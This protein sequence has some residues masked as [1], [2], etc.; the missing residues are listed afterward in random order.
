MG[1][2]AWSQSPRSSPKMSVE[3][4]EPQLRIAV[5]SAPRSGNTWLRNMLAASFSLREIAVHRPEHVDWSALP[6]RVVLQTHWDPVEP[7]LGL[8]HR[9]DFRVVTV[10]RHPLDL[11]L[12]LLNL[13]QY[14]E[15]APHWD[16]GKSGR[17]LV[18][19][20]PRSPDFLEFACG[21]MTASLLSPTLRWLRTPGTVSVRYEDLV[22][23]TTGTLTRVTQALSS[24]AR[25]PADEVA[26][27]Y[28]IERLRSGYGV[29]HYHYWQGRPGHWKTLLTARE[30]HQIASAHAAAFAELGYDC[31]PDTDLDETQA[32]L[33]WYRLQCNSICKHL[34]DERTKHRL[35][36]GALESKEEQLA[37]AQSALADAEAQAAA[38]LHS[39]A[40]LRQECKARGRALA[41]AH[42]ELD[43]IRQ[44]SGEFETLGPYSLKV[45][46][47]V[48]NFSR[49]HPLLASAVKQLVRGRRKTA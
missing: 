25:Q 34:A 49:R 30:A 38:A 26:P 19:A 37:A 24:D 1:T 15:E 17:T 11:F 27:A 32:D 43:S 5:I 10:A 18:G 46:R 36:R 35:T 6:A 31:D 16:E 28:A 42:A 48:Q 33:N 21:R 22:A 39:L 9:H 41:T 2:E 8:L 7:L 45:A 13:R 44:H 20:S 12:S 3:P 29:W 47:T 23:D 14:A 4:S 40:E